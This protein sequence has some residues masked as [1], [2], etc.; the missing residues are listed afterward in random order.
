MKIV[1]FIGIPGVG[2]STIR[3]KLVQQLKTIKPHSFL[4]SEEAFLAVSRRHTDLMYRTV[5]KPLPDV[6]A[7]RIAKKISSRT[8]FQFEAQNNFLA[9][10]GQAFKAYLLSDKFQNTHVSEKSGLIAAF[11]QVGSL[12][13]LISTNFVRESFVFFEE[14]LVQKSFMFLSPQSC[15]QDVD[16]KQ[17]TSYLEHIPLPDIII[18]AKADINTC[19]ARMQS[20]PGGLTTRLK[21][22]DSETILKFL[23]TTSNHLNNVTA[24]LSSNS[25]VI[26]IEANNDDSMGKILITLK[27]A[28]VNLWESHDVA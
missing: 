19:F 14:G 16:E 9:K 3:E 11:L 17:L 7:L 15:R 1:E 21:N 28:I 18:Y 2:K 8:L 25:K 24:K 27:N 10:Y 23:Q 20:R 4:K 26:I 13:E 12:L 5:L 22:A 6:I